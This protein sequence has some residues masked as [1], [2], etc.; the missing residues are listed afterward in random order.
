MTWE[1]CST[2][3]M[4][5]PPRT[6]HCNFCQK[7][8]LKRDHH[9]FMVGTCIGYKNQRYFVVLAFYAVLC[10]IGGG[11]LTYSYL[12][13]MFLPTSYAWTDYLFPVAIYR[14]LTGASYMTGHYAL[15]IICV[16]FHWRLLS[17]GLTLY[18][19]TK[20]VPV[21]SFNS[22]N[23]NFRSVFGDFWVLN[24]IF[25]MQIIFRQREDGTK[26]EGCKIRLQC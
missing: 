6:H 25:P 1:Y 5:I 7:C 10:G 17:K 21:K 18:E 16:R 23:Y 22:I 20:R 14:W 4:K 11:L 2:C 13:I 15:L 12:K 3:D 8:I 9:C 19:L 26:W 24:F